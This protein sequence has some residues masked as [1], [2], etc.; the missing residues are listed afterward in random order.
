MKSNNFFRTGIEMRKVFYV[1]FAISF[2]FSLYFIEQAVVQEL[3]GK[4][5]VLNDAIME[6]KLQIK[7]LK[8]KKDLLE[9]YVDYLATRIK[10]LS[11]DIESF[12]KNYAV[13]TPSSKGYS[14]VN[15]ELGN[16]LVS[17]DSLTKYANGYK[18]IFNIGNPSQV[19]YS[20]LKV[21]VSWGAYENFP[22]KVSSGNPRG[23]RTNE[24]TINKP[25][26][27]GLWNK[28]SV[29]LS[30]ATAKETG[31]IILRLSADE[32]ALKNDYRG[33]GN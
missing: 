31:I 7:D 14:T 12:K 9:T 4:N 8:S 5:V 15:T 3:N 13:F 22:S 18:I 11:D 20:G 23:F 16:F 17:L 26:L 29:I 2:V 19:T 33:T 27:P 25:I 10:N 28:V 6:S 30:P 24:F 32:I 21:T 1:F